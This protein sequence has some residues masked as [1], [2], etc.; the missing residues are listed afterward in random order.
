M[1]VGQIVKSVGVLVAVVAGL[2]GGFPESALVIAVLGAVGGY[3]IEEDDACLLRPG[4]LEELADHPS[5]LA[6][7]LLYKLATDDAN[8]GGVGSVGDSS[9]AESLA[10]TGGTVEK[11]TLWRV[12]AEVDKPL[13]GEQGHLDDFPQLLYLLLATTHIA[14]RDIGLLL[15]GHH[16]DAGVNLGRQRQ[17]DLVLVA[18]D[19]D[20]HALF[21]VGRADAVAELDDELCD[22]LDVNNVLLLR[23]VALLVFDYLRTS[24]YLE[25]LFF[26][27]SLTIGGHVPQMRW[28]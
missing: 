19:T 15:H 12:D 4:H 16:G 7:V 5:A 21:D 25:G 23:F 6:D 8:E 27:H 11:G 3:F 2:M 13:R 26:R 18:V 20:A 17:H 24:C 9:S 28:C 10:G 1:G 14:I 22:L